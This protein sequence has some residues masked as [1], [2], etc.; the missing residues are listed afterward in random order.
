MG[1]VSINLNGGVSGFKDSMQ[2]LKS[3]GIESGVKIH[4]TTTTENG[5]TTY[6]TY[7]SDNRKGHWW[8]SSKRRQQKADNAMAALTQFVSDM[9]T[10]HNFSDSDRLSANA[11]VASVFRDPK[12]A[13]RNL[14]TLA[15]H[16]ENAAGTAPWRTQ[17]RANEATKQTQME[18]NQI[19]QGI[20]NGQKGL[21]NPKSDFAKA[22]SKNVM[23][24]APKTPKAPFKVLNLEDELGAM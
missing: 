11:M 1:H 12:N 21:L 10:K 22:M 3:R 19:S 17:M 5:K 9:A 23:P 15:N 8:G 13:V 24:D 2:D 14:H 4:A 18:F 16:L 6:H 7:S 20:Q